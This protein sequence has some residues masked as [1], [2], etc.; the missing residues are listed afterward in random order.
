MAA[1]YTSFLFIGC[2]KWTCSKSQMRIYAASRLLKFSLSSINLLFVPC[3]TYR[4]DTSPLSRI[5]AHGFMNLYTDIKYKLNSGIVRPPLQDSESVSRFWY[6]ETLCYVE[7]SINTC[8]LFKWTQRVRL[9]GR[10][11]QTFETEA[12]LSWE[13]SRFVNLLAPELFFKF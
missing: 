1:W 12:L 11:Y 13:Q 6:S 9:K 8:R 7:G 10:T 2:L 3:G 5:L 4:S